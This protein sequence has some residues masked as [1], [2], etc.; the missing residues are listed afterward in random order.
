MKNNL[1]PASILRFIAIL[2][3]ALSLA[4]PARAQVVFS[5]P[6]APAGGLNVSSWIPPNGN[7]ADV[8]AWDDFT[9][10]FTQTITR[11]QWRGGYAFGGLF[12]QAYDFRVSFF[13]SGA[14]GT[15]PLI[16]AFPSHPSAETVIATFHTLGTAGETSFGTI[17]GVTMYD[18]DFV[19]PTPV[20]LQGGVKYWFRVVALQPTMPDWG[21]ATASGGDGLHY[22]FI[23]SFHTFQV[24][25]H[26]LA[27]TLCAQWANVGQGLTGT[28]GVPQLTGSGSL[29]GGSSGAL[30]L[31]AAWPSS[32]I[33]FVVGSSEISLPL[34]GGTL[35]PSPDFIYGTATLASGSATLPF[36]WPIGVPA[37]TNIVC[38][39]WVLDPGGV[40]G[41]AASNGL[42]AITP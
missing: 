19:L 38:Q 6:I 17:G 29:L 22:R 30:T 11:V 27:F 34:A 1:H 39:A 9:L 13:A 24:V 32:L 33:W 15:Q 37:A 3:V 2:A 14:G 23:E 25:P 10:A 7:N 35:V 20:T 42:V 40:A 28:T 26:D 12:G 16:T 41:L 4:L 5:Q 31:S 36:V 18:Y 21:M 8:Y